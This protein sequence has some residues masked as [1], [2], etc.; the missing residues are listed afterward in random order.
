MSDLRGFAPPDIGDD[1]HIIRRLGWAVVRLWPDLLDELQERI[2]HLAVSTADR[3][4]TVQLN[5]QIQLFLKNHTLT[6]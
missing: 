5:E 1:E 3:Y 4:A 6:A 2:R